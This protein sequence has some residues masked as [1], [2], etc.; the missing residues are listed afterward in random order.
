MTKNLVR[1]YFLRENSTWRV[2][3]YDEVCFFRRLCWPYLMVLWWLLGSK[4]QCVVE[5]IHTCFSLLIFLLGHMQM[6]IGKMSILGG[7][8]IV[9]LLRMVK[10]MHTSG[11]CDVYP[12]VS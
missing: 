7:T 11:G 6:F 8:S 5:H 1:L 9:L 4:G 12:R 10:G 2:N 3:K